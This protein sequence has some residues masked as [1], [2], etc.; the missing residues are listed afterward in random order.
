MESR[1]L[2][3]LKA[4]VAKKAALL[5]RVERLDEKEIELY[6]KHAAVKRYCAVQHLRDQYKKELRELTYSLEAL[7]EGIVKDGEV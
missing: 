3:F 5:K 7:A 4:Q 2:R 6:S 1:R